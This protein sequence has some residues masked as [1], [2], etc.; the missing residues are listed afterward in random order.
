MRTILSL[1]NDSTCKSIP[2]PSRNSDKVL[3]TLKIYQNSG[4]NSRSCAQNTILQSQLTINMSI[5][6]SISRL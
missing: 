5:M 2:I 1:F 3:Y 6:S 4:S